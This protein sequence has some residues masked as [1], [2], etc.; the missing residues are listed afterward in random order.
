[1]MLVL[2]VQSPLV[3]VTICVVY[4]RPLEPLI[5]THF[6]ITHGTLWPPLGATKL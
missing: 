5:R 1:M 2:F 4:V 3:T 6:A